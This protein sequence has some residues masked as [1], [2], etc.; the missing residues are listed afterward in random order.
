MFVQ[1]AQYCPPPKAV[2]HD[3]VITRELTFAMA[4]L[5]SILLGGF[6]CWFGAAL[7]PSSSP[8]IE[9]SGAAVQ[10]EQGVP[11]DLDSIQVLAQPSQM[12][13]SDNRTMTVTLTAQGSAQAEKQ[14]VLE[15]GSLMRREVESSS[16]YSDDDGHPVPVYIPV[17]VPVPAPCPP[18]KARAQ[19]QAHPPDYV[20]PYPNAHY[21]PEESPYGHLVPPDANS[22]GH[23]HT[24][25][26]PGL[27][28]HLSPNAWEGAGPVPDDLHPKDFREEA[29]AVFNAS[30]TMAHAKGED[31][32]AGKKVQPDKVVEVTPDAEEAK[33]VTTPEPAEDKEEKSQEAAVDDAA[34]KEVLKSK[35]E[36]EFKKDVVQEH[37]EEETNEWSEKTIA[38]VAIVSL[39]AC[40]AFTVIGFVV[41]A[42]Y[43]YFIAG[44]KD[45]HV[46]F[47]PASHD[48]CVQPPG[49]EASAGVTQ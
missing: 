13:G 26:A 4:L 16:A 10:D 8:R 44:A 20:S 5:K 21:D 41:G 39:T 24:A 12:H 38:F 37:K 22:S 34:E 18:S 42:A 28:E 30:N 15:S 43:Y 3:P 46:Q 7:S 47:D 6:F 9:L 23:N 11:I 14:Q 40:L 31:E 2:A 1:L 25:E 17:P 19:S 45:S 32:E 33:P 35:S 36:E 29:G 49:G 27:G 48:S